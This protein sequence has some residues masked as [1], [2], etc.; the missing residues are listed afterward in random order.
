MDRALKR[1]QDTTANWSA[2]YDAVGAERVKD[3]FYHC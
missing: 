1:S 3:T 2:L